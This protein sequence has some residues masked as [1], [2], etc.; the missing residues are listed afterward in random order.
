MA[1][2]PTQA[3]DSAWGFPAVIKSSP[4]TLVNLGMNSTGAPLATISESPGRR[5][6]SN[7]RCAAGRRKSASIRRTRAA[8]S[9]MAKARL[10]AVVDFPSCGDPLVMTSTLARMERA[11]LVTIK[12]DARDGRAKRVSLTE[13]G[14]TMREACIVAGAALVPVVGALMTN[15]ELAAI[16]PPLTRLRSALDHMR[17]TK[18]PT[19]R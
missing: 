17:D 4:D 16:L 7:A 3:D 14:R 2:E 9:F 6:T 19:D 8:I 13:K 18:T 12:A 15:A 11:G 10:T 1:S 5:G